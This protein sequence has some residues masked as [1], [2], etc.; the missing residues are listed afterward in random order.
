[1][2]EL[3][4]VELI[5]EYRAGSLSPVEVTE[6][7][8]ARIEARE[9]ELHA[10]YAFDP[11]SARAEAKALEARWQQGEPLGP[12]DGVPLTLKEN[13]A[14]RGTPVPLGTAATELTPAPADAPAA[15]RIH[16]SGGILLAKTTMPD[17]GMLTSGLSSFHTAARNPWDTE[18]TTGGSSA[19]AAAA[20]AAGYAPL[21]VGT[22]IG[23]SIR[24][25][26]GWCGLAGLKPSFGRVPVDPPFLGRAAGPMTRTVADAALLMNVLS[27]PDERDHWGLPPAETP[28]DELDLDLRGLRLGL[29]LDPGVGLDVEPD[30]RAAVVEAARLLEA[31][32]AIVEPVEPFLTR[33]MLDGLDRFWRVRA[34]SDL[35]QIS[36]ERRRQ[37]LPYI[38]E[39]ATSGAGISGLDTYRGFAQMDVMSLAAL[40]AI[41]PFDFVLSPTCPV[42]APP[43]EWASPTNDPQRPFEHIAFTVPY[44][45]SGQPAISVNCGYT[46]H[47]QPIGLQI[48]GRRFDDLG[49]LRLAGAFER[50]RPAQLPWP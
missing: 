29:H 5:A 27:R 19:G 26:A 39:W 17:Y 21:H 41:E 28:W 3:T 15:A 43:A 4:A 49:V 20:A 8:I 30:I 36:E 47:S 7:A 31:Q 38:A 35:S 14:T 1:M 42:S 37:V 9:P 50:V 25:P 45:M 22:D 13:I 33:E 16:E 23:G 18:R 34:W 11:A 44:N 32:G 6:A 40:R 48:A 24:L 2:T 10:L 12:I 46:G